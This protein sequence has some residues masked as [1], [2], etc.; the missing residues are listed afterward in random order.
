MPSRL[1]QILIPWIPWFAKDTDGRPM[2][3]ATDFH[4][5]IKFLIQPKLVLNVL[6]IRGR[7]KRELKTP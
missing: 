7:E 5:R 6:N 2:N 3:R 4:Y 1:N